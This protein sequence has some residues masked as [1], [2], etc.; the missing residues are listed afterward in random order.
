MRATP[1][2]FAGLCAVLLVGGKAIATPVTYQLSYVPGGEVASLAH[3]YENVTLNDSARSMSE[4]GAAGPLTL[5]IRNVQTGAVQLLELLCTD[6]F[7]D[8]VSGGTY[9]LGRLS[10]TLHDTVKLDQIEALI[11]NGLSGATDN[12]SAAALQLAVWEIQNEPGLSG[13]DVASGVFTVTGYGGAIDGN[14]VNEANDDLGKVVSG[15]WKPDPKEI[16]YQ[17]EP[18]GGAEY[19]N[20]TFAYIAPAPAPEPA[21][22]SLLGVGMIGLSLFARRR[23]AT[24]SG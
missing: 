21:A 15:T 5:D 20:Q 9:T 14:M 16:V 4:S 24:T 6:V 13:Y 22:A 2:V 23:R 19:P 18:A 3:G 1:L 12:A 10:D 7:D 17:F 8:Y 11:Q